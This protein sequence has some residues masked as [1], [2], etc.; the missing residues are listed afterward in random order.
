MLEFIGGVDLAQR[1]IEFLHWFI[2]SVFSETLL[3]TAL[4]IPPR[5]VKAFLFFPGFFW[6]EK[7]KSSFPDDNP[8]P[9]HTPASVTPPRS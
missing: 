9:T 1:L 7:K 3:G 8:P 6:G 4:Q 5:V 2:L